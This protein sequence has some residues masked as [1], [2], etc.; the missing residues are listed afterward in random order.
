MSNLSDFLVGKGYGL[1]EVLTAS[2]TWNWTTA[3]KPKKVFVRMIAGGG[4]NAQNATGSNGTDGG[5]SVWDTGAVVA[6][7]TC[8]GGGGATTSTGGTITG[9]A[10]QGG[11]LNEGN[12]GS[13]TVRNSFINIFGTSDNI[14]I[15]QEGWCG[16]MGELKMF[17]YD[18]VGNVVYT[19]GSGGS[20][21]N[22]DTGDGIQ[23]AIELYY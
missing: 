1:K 13:S 16:G 11:V 21:G 22:P 9:N 2:G 5:D 4:G 7:T 20:E 12:S 10:V 8:V 14:K 23:G 15:Q 3:G 6:T 17:D 18:P 19:I